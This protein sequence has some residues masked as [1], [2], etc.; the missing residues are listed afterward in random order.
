MLLFSQGNSKYHYYGIRVRSSSVL[1]DSVN[2][3]V[4]NSA[5]PP[6]KKMKP[7]SGLA[8]TLWQFCVVNDNLLL[9]EKAT[10]SQNVLQ[11]PNLASSKESLLS[12]L[13]NANMLLDTM[14]PNVPIESQDESQKFMRKY[15]AHYDRIIKALSVLGF[16]EIETIWLSF[17]Q[18]EGM[19]DSG[20]QIDASLIIGI[21]GFLPDR[22]DKETMKNLAKT[23]L[24]DWITQTDYTMYNSIISSLL[25]PN[26]LK[27]IPQA[28]TQQIR[29]FA[30]C[31][32]RWMRNALSGYDGNPQSLFDFCLT[33]PSQSALFN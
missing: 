27:Q 19:D 25:L 22:M 17:W 4:D 9:T 31:I 11:T 23:S 13:G 5:I 30:K 18:A 32:D 15:R 26:L 14:W 28:L 10:E 2:G 21:I 24:Q 7:N 12:Y 1:N 8:K 20:K 3:S 16:H 29:N 33:F 6:I